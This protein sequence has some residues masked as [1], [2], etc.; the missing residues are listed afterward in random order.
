MWKWIP[1]VIQIS[2]KQINV[3]VLFDF[4]NNNQVTMGL[5]KNNIH[6]FAIKTF[7]IIYY[8]KLLFIQYG[9][10]GYKN[11]RTSDIVMFILHI[12]QNICNI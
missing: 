10:G 1:N 6:S 7:K 2:A 3:P 4:T 12:V 11:L 8:F 5:W 9:G